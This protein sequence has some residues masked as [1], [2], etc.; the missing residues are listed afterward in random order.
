MIFWKNIT[1][2][3]LSVLFFVQVSAQDGVLSKP[4]GTVIPDYDI[5][6]TK[7]SVIDQQDNSVLFMQ[8]T[9][10]S[11]HQ[12]EK[13]QII[14]YNLNSKM[15]K[16]NEIEY[17]KEYQ[18]IASKI[19]RDQLIHFFF[20]HNTRARTIKLVSSETSMPE[21]SQQNTKL[22]F[23]E[24]FTYAVNPKTTTEA[25]YAESN[26]K[27]Y[28]ALT[29]VTKDENQVIQNVMAVALNQNMEIEWMELFNPDFEGRTSDVEDVQISEKGKILVLL[30][31][32]ISV[33]RKQSDHQL[34][35]LSLHKNNDFT[36]FIVPTTFG[37]IQSMKLLVLKNENY[38]V[39]GYYAEK[40]N[41]TTVGYFT[42][43]FDP[44]R[45]NEVITAYQYYFSESYKE[46]EAVGYSS[47]TKPNNEYNFKCDYLW[48][49]E[50]DFVIM[51]GEQYA[52]TSTVNPKNKEVTY[53]YFF[54]DLYYHYF[55]LDGHTAGYDFVPKPQHGSS[56]A[57]P[58]TDYTQKGLSYYAFRGGRS[59]YVVYNESIDQYDSDDWISFNS[60]NIKEAALSLC[61]IDKI[62]IEFKVLVTP[63]IKDTFFNRVWFADG[64]NILLGFRGKKDYQ[65][66]KLQI[67]SEWDWD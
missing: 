54:K 36:Q 64:Y 22:E 10:T 9:A 4:E 7:L 20:V 14:D 44:R 40:Q 34:K 57:T 42:Y 62:G 53:N 21:R 12:R 60:D 58:I 66:E 47:P 49:L 38:F 30:N 6:N 24:V 65:V 45:E 33:K 28:F 46:R 41:R 37:L 29:L 35:L 48:E 23:D 3:L 61:R 39:A 1:I 56:V 50:D 43:T 27:N 17:P 15:L 32:Y 8:R 16:V 31:D 13:S 26:D 63:P 51:L 52:E 19:K 67:S 59:I 5:L 11:P 2:T 55:A 18:Y 25:Y